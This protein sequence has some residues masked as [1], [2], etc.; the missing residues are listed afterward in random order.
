MPRQKNVILTLKNNDPSP[1]LKYL[2]SSAACMHPSIHKLP[3]NPSPQNLT[4]ALYTRTT[5]AA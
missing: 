3:R 4:L 2:S 1:N 5:I